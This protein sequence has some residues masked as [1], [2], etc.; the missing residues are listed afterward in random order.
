MARGKKKS[1]RSSP[2]KLLVLLFVFIILMAT[3]SAV[4]TGTSAVNMSSIMNTVF[5]MMSIGVILFLFSSLIRSIWK[6]RRGYIINRMWYGVAD[7]KPK[8]RLYWSDPSLTPLKKVERTGGYQKF[9]KD[10]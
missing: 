5:I 8:E 4:I 2:M 9:W 10:L 1:K 3:Y 6:H 7:N